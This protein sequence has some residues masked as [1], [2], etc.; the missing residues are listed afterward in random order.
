M[1]P[2]SATVMVVGPAAASHTLLSGRLSVGRKAI[3]GR[4]CAIRIIRTHVRPAGEAESEIEHQFELLST[5]RTPSDKTH[6]PAGIRA[7]RAW[8]RK[9]P[10]RQSRRDRTRR[11]RTWLGERPAGRS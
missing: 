5:V 10:E 7:R 11:A 2:P 3:A 4:T 6:G 1:M 8:A 9:S